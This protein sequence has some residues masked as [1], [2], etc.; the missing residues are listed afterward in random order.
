MGLFRTLAGRYRFKKHLNYDPPDYTMEEA[1]K[2]RHGSVI[3]SYMS[4]LLIIVIGV[5]TKD[6]C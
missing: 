1:Y 6:V 3:V 5:G 2:D 4:C